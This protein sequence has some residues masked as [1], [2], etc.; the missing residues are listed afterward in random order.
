MTISSVNDAIDLLREMLASEG[1]RRRELLARLEECLPD[2]GGSAWEY[3][4]EF[5]NDAAYYEPNVEW[6]SE[7]ESLFG[8]ERLDFEIRATLQKIAGVD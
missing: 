1:T 2:E 8:D 5:V 7:D 4:Y 6:R 3:L